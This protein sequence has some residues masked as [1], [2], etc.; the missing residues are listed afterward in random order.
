MR[1]PPFR[2][3]RA[4]SHVNRLNLNEC[5]Y[6]Q[7]SLDWPKKTAPFLLPFSRYQRSSFYV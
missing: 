7:I 2:G 1:F 5:N 3:R 6:G 4:R